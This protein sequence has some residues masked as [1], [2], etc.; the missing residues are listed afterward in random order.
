ME[1]YND[2]S[3]THTSQMK[4]LPWHAVLD[5]GIAKSLCG[6]KLVAQMAQTGAREGKRVGY[7]R[8]TEAVDESYHFRGIGH[9]IF[10]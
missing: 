3:K 9:P 2:G 6:A 4:V 7:E 8:D 10:S 5:C 1:F